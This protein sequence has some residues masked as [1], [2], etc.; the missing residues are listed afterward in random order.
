MAVRGE[1]MM[2]GKR[3]FQ[4][5]LLKRGKWKTQGAIETGQSPS[6]AR[7]DPGE[8]SLGNSAKAHGNKRVIGNSQ[9]IANHA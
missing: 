8:D 7:Q 9:L 3:E 5:Q 1:S 6:C 4:H 2:A